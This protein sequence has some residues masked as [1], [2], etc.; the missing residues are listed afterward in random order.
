MFFST[1]EE[2]ENKRINEVMGED[3]FKSNFWLFWRTTFAFQEW[4]S[5][6]E[7]K[8]YLHRFTHWISSLATSARREPRRWWQFGLL[9]PPDAV[10]PLLFKPVRVG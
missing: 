10:P 9:E 2:M 8:L 7:L 3:F 5:A 6:L 4:H 1:R